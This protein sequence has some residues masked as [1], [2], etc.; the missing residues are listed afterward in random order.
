MQRLMRKLALLDVVDEQVGSGK[1]DL[2]IQLPYT[3]KS[4]QRRAQAE[5]RR[6]DI[7]MQLASSK[8]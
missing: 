6:K 1:L 4:E 3:I 2:I 7:E 5:Q 8:Y